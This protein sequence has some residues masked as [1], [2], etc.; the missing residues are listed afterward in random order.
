MCPFVPVANTSIEE[1]VDCAKS[2]AEQLATELSVPVYL[3]ESAQAKEYRRE[4]QSI[5]KGEYEGLEVK[6]TGM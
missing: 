6:V 1:C 3:Y 4:L 5:R 2:L